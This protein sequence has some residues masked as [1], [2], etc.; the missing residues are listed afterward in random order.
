MYQRS[1]IIKG[2]IDF[3]PSTSTRE[4]SLNQRKMTSR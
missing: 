2:P 3:N 1:G 4:S